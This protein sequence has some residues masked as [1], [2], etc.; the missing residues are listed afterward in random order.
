MLV[1][2][3]LGDVLGWSSRGRH[4]NSAWLRKSHT[5]ATSWITEWRRA[6][7]CKIEVCSS[8]RAAGSMKIP[9]VPVRVQVLHRRLSQ[10]AHL[11][12]TSNCIISMK[13]F[14]SP[15]TSRVDSMVTNKCTRDVHALRQQPQ[16]R[17]YE[18]HVPD[19]EMMCFEC[20]KTHNNVNEKSVCF[21]PP[22]YTRSCRK[23]RRGCDR[24]STSPDAV[25][26]AHESER[27]ATDRDGQMFVI[28][29]I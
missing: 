6:E 21:G 25:C 8:Q 23:S 7:R 14:H 19:H 1:L 17:S 22:K 20:E 29:H 18:T 15:I 11:P 2:A 26:F 10:K 5:M 28:A 13:H 4:Q 16:W 12:D 24:R 27:R 9:R 3:K